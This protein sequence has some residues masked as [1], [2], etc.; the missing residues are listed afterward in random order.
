MAVKMATG[1]IDLHEK[2]AVSAEVQSRLSGGPAIAGKISS[3]RGTASCC[4]KVK[5]N[6]TKGHRLHVVDYKN[7]IYQYY[8]QEPGLVNG[9][10]HYPSA[11]KKKAIW[12]QGS[13]WSIGSTEDRGTST[14]WA[15]DGSL[16]QPGCP[17]SI[18]YTWKYYSGEHDA[19]IKAKKGL[20][21]WCKS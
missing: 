2:P 10:V 12:Y 8:T 9:Y 20:S 14:S 21:I 3:K 1:D 16:S 6:Y 19:W 4:W 7:D 15:F 11:D 13:S 5:V 17:D 18:R